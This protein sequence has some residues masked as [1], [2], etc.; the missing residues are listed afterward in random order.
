MTYASDSAATYLSNAYCYLDTGD[1]QPVAPSAE[2]LT[3]MTNKGFILL[4]NRICA[5]RDV[6]LFGRLHSDICNVPLYSLP[7]IRLQIRLTEA[8]P[9]FYLMKK[10][11]YSKTVFKYL[12]AQL[13]VRRVR[14][15][16]DILLAHTATLKKR[17]GLA[18]SN[19]TRVELKTFTFRAGSKSLFKTS[20]PWSHPETSVH[21][22]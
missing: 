14:P 5:S 12:D 22:G 2:N 16:P 11:V 10:S 15:N 18:L 20:L 19:L 13:L 7:G 3:A 8:R 1:M 6:Q 9:S 21:H 4:W 17:E